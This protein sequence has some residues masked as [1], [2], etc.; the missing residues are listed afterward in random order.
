MR[1]PRLQNHAILN[2]TKSQSKQVLVPITPVYFKKNK[3][4]K[5]QSLFKL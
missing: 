4:T 5:I 3:T 2:L 1:P